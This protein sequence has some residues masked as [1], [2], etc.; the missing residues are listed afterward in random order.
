MPKRP[1][2]HPCASKVQ[3]SHWQ[4]QHPQVLEQT[5]KNRSI[6]YIQEYS[7]GDCVLQTRYLV[8]VSDDEKDACP[9]QKQVGG[10]S[11]LNERIGGGYRCRCCCLRFEW[12]CWFSWR[13]RGLEL[14]LVLIRIV[15]LDLSSCA[16]KIARMLNRRF[17][18]GC[19]LLRLFVGEYGQSC[20]K[21]ET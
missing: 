18:D 9:E 6:D 11:Q 12:S 20:C 15:E 13:M 3:A 8:L 10:K 4:I 2:S 19:H 14:L 17:D 16:R 5:P 21:R 7:V 1:H